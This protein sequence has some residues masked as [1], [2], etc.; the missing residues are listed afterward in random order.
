MAH[1]SLSGF[2]QIPRSADNASDRPKIKIKRLPF[3][4]GKPPCGD[5]VERA[6]LSASI[7]GAYTNKLFSQYLESFADY[8]AFCPMATIHDPC[9]DRELKERFLTYH[10][11]H[12]ETYTHLDLY[13]NGIQTGRGDD[14][15]G[16]AS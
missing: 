6:I 12:K 3:L 14:Y 5:G 15:H 1:N 10:E 7:L 9:N 11:H 13:F 8:A 2:E 16:V 4:T